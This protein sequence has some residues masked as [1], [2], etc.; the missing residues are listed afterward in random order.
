MKNTQRRIL[1][2]GAALL[3]STFAP[4]TSLYAQDSQV[5]GRVLDPTQAAVSSA[6]VVLTQADTGDRRE[7]ASNAEGYYTFPLLVP[8]M[9]DLTV[10]K[11]GF[12]SQTRKGIKVETGQISAVDVTLALGD[13]SQSVSVDATVALLQA[14][15][16]AVSDVVENATIVDM[17]LI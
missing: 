11:A 6:A 12:Q 13:I 10:Q 8:G 7:A 5:S 2:Y 14:D 1:L 17:P 16:A 9:Y 4:F 3:V 15:T